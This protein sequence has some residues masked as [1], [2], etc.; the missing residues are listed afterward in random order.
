MGA[1]FVVI[2]KHATFKSVAEPV[3]GLVRITP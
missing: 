3:P 2:P 1:A